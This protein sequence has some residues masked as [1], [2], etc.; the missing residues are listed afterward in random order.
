MSSPLGV[1]S[2]VLDKLLEQIHNHFKGN[3]VGS[4]DVVVEIIKPHTKTSYVEHYKSTPKCVGKANMFVSHAW[5]CNVVSLLETLLQYSKEQSHEV[6]FWLDICCN[7]Q[8]EIDQASGDSKMTWDWWKTSFVSLLNGCGQVL[9]VASPFNKPEVCSRAWCLFEAVTATLKKLP[10]TVRVPPSEE[11]DLEKAI[12]KDAQIMIK[13]MMNINSEQAEA[14]V[15][16]DLRNIRAM[17]EEVDGQYGTVDNVFKVVLREWIAVTGQ[18]LFSKKEDGSKEKAFFANQIGCILNGVGNY[19]KAIE[20]YNQSLG[21]Q[22]KV[23][24]PDHPDTAASYNNI[25]SAYDNKGDYDKAIELY[26]QSLGIRLK[27]LGP[28]HPDTAASKRNIRNIE[29]NRSLSHCC[30]CQ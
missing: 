9:I 2:I 7:N 11:T 10:V 14:T 25:G 5:K 23:L 18:D 29:Q 12:E 19:D 1:S 6:Y 22:L 15:Q 17:I 21:I 28:D 26:N 16:E 20:L 8:H 27:V 3:V 30:C 13:V 4:K 24:G